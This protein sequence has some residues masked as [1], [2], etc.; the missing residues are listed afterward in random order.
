MNMTGANI[1]PRLSTLFHDGGG[2]WR[3]DRP[4]REEDALGFGLSALRGGGAG[5][6]GGVSISLPS[7]STQ[8]SSHSCRLFFSWRRRCFLVGIA[9]MVALLVRPARDHDAPADVA[10]E[11]IGEV[12]PVGGPEEGDV[13]PEAGREPTAVLPAEDVGR[14]DRAGSERLCGRQLQLGRRERADERQALAERAPGVEVRRERDCG[15][16]VDESPR[17]RLRAVEEERAR[18]QE[19]A[20]DVARAEGGDAGR[21]R[22]LEMVDG[23]RA[24]LDREGDRS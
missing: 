23:A 24:E 21:A 3:T 18:R 19:D 10:T 17:R 12:A 1:A 4:P 20:D 16:G 5:A 15:A 22:R 13:G 11:V 14:V 9:A 6:S 8:T 7:S 2:T